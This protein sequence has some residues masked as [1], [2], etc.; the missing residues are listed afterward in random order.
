MLRM[1][2]AEQQGRNQTSARQTCGIL[3][4]RQVFL[5]DL[6]TLCLLCEKAFCSC[7]VALRPRGV[8]PRPPWCF[9]ESGEAKNLNRKEG[10]AKTQRRPQRPPR[11]VPNE[12][13]CRDASQSSA[14][15]GFSGNATERTV[16]LF[17]RRRYVILSNDSEGHYFKHDC[18]RRMDN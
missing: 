1:C 5:C 17:R 4:F 3:F 2:F 14:E 13:S 9:P 6:C 11:I 7:L 12:E 18:W 16:K 10:L 15:E 8:A